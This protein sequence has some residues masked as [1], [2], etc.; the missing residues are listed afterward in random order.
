MIRHDDDDDDQRLQDQRFQRQPVDGCR[1]TLEADNQ[2]P[3]AEVSSQ[4]QG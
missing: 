3:A 1:T 4:R 2:L